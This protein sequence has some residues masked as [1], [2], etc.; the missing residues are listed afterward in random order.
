MWIEVS[1]KNLLVNLDTGVRIELV[2]PVSVC[3]LYSLVINMIGLAY[4]ADKENALEALDGLRRAVRPTVKLYL[5]GAVESPDPFKMLGLGS[6][7]AKTEDAVVSEG[8]WLDR[9]K[10]LGIA[11]EKPKP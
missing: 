10:A 1:G 9:A 5:V 2:E 4:F 8:D 11:P 6:P 3:P 7:F